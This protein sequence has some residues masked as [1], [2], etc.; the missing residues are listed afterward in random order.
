MHGY[1]ILKPNGAITRSYSITLTR[2]DLLLTIHL[3]GTLPM[4]GIS[5]GIEL[6]ANYSMNK[7]VIKTAYIQELRTRELFQIWLDNVKT[8]TVRRGHIKLNQV[9][10]TPTFRALIIGSFN[11]ELTP[12]GFEFW[13][14]VAHKPLTL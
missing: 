12:E 3:P 13:D 11:W 4:R 7:I 1:V 10:D 2:G 14:K 8:D 5:T 9:P 6:H